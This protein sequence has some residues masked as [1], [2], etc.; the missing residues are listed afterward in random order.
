VSSFTIMMD[1]HCWSVPF[2]PSTCSG[3]CRATIMLERLGILYLILYLLI[4]GTKGS[5]MLI[6][7][8]NKI[9]PI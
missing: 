3:I 1:V 6:L 5:T 2:F 4:G 8:L 9:L 7:R